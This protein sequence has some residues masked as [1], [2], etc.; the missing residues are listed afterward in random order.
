MNTQQAAY[1]NV[2]RA[3]LLSL[4]EADTLES[5]DDDVVKAY[6]TQRDS[7]RRRSLDEMSALCQELG[8]YNE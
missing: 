2:S 8:F 5:L 6:K 1:L 4:L 7:Q 3:Y